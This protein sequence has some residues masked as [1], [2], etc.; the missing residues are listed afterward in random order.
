MGDDSI[1]AML[2]YSWQRFGIN[3]PC[4]GGLRKGKTSKSILSSQNM[5]I[6]ITCMRHDRSTSWEFGLVSIP[7]TRR[8]VDRTLP[9]IHLVKAI[10]RVLFLI[11]F[12]MFSILHARTSN[13]T[14][15]LL[16]RVKQRRRLRPK[17]RN[18]SPQSTTKVHPCFTW[19]ASTI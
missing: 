17:R 12:I 10:S 15:S 14:H 7:K 1:F 6:C 8:F 3:K 16:T 9:K 4:M 11:M 13:I 19:G 2:F 18:G 5:Y